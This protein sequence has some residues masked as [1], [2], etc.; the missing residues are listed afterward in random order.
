MACIRTICVHTALNKSRL[1]ARV[2][3]LIMNM[4]GSFCG[5]YVRVPFCP[6]RLVCA[7]EIKGCR[8]PPV[9]SSSPSVAHT[10]IFPPSFH[11]SF[12]LSPFSYLFALSLFFVSLYSYV[13][14]LRDHVLRLVLH[15]LLFSYGDLCV[16]FI[17]GCDRVAAL[18][19]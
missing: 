4:Y 17:S 18:I 8:P 1:C 15:C 14:R 9:H 19:T 7:C 11:F 2:R 16:T 5:R 3:V 13:R 6:A 10:C 12:F